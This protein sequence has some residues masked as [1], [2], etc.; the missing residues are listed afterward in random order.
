M[1]ICGLVSDNQMNTCPGKQSNKRPA[2]TLIELLVVIAIIAILAALLLPVISKAE[3]QARITQCIN[4]F[5]QLAL[6]WQTYNN[7]DND[8]LPRNWA[9]GNPPKW[10]WCMGDGSENMM[11]NPTDVTGITNGVLFPFTKSATIYRCPD[12]RPVRGNQVEQRTCSM[13]VRMGGGNAAD[14]AQYGVWDS[15]S[16]DLSSDLETEFPMYKKLTQIRS[17]SPGDSLLFVDE[18]QNTVD[19]EVLGLDWDDWKNSP[20]ERHVRGCVFSFADGHA[21]RWQWL[22][23]DREQGY[24]FTP[25]NAAQLHD[26]RRFL[27]DIVATNAP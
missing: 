20:T 9:L 24:N 18:S 27:G 12:A 4:N 10:A 26:L 3:E 2:F 7:D 22:G 15:G 11:S 14:S 6:A 21:E 23:M 25:Q 19:D 17:P 1:L 5:K 13:I 16:S 8:W